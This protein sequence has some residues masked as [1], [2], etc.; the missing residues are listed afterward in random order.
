MANDNSQTEIWNSLPG[1]SPVKSS[2]II[3]RVSPAAAKTVRGYHFR[4]ALRI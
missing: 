2:R 3:Q 4:S 1:V